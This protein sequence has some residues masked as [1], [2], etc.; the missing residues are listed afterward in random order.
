MLCGSTWEAT[1][2]LKEDRGGVDG[3]GINEKKEGTGEKGGGET[4]W[5]AK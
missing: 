1:T 5:Y 3:E 2:F 4:G